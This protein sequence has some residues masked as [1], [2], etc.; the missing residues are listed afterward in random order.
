MT[1]ITRKNKRRG[2]TVRG[3]GGR[4]PG[5]KNNTAVQMIRKVA[6]A[7]GK[8]LLRRAEHG[9][10]EAMEACIRLAELDDE[11][12]KRSYQGWADAKARTTESRTRRG[13]AQSALVE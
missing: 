8:E 5:R 9:E 1:S 4:P 11:D 3:T 10:I 2:P 13:V 6:R 12:L 7:L